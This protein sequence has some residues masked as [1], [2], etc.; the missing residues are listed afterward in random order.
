MK[1]SRERLQTI[2]ATCLVVAH[3]RRSSVPCVES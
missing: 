3:S 1:V 2:L